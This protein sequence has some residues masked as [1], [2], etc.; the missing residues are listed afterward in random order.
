M[1]T[2]GSMTDLVAHMY[3]HYLKSTILA[4]AF[5]KEFRS[6]L[7]S[8]SMLFSISNKTNNVDK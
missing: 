7:T 4:P 2:L 3:N 8:F 1:L 5:W 6:V